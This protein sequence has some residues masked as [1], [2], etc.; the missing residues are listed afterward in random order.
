MEE[1]VL[2]SQS[3]GRGRSSA[4]PQK[5]LLSHNGNATAIKENTWFKGMLLVPWANRIAYV[6]SVSHTDIFF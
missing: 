6:S 1:L 3:A 2:A 5:I 4:K